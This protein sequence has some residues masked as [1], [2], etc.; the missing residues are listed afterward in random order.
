MSFG[1]KTSNESG[2]NKSCIEV[3]SSKKQPRLKW[4]FQ[5]RVERPT[6]LPP[7]LKFQ[8][9]LGMI[10]IFVNQL[11]GVRKAFIWLRRV[12]NIAQKHIKDKSLE[13]EVEIIVKGQKAYGIG[14]RFNK[15][16]L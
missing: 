2:D 3:E 13:R 8:T 11:G 9:E 4:I 1:K 5:T 14:V 6:I 10:Q 16:G 7:K 15:T 12:R